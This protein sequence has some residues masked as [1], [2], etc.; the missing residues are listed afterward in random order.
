MR[1]FSSRVYVIT[2]AAIA[3]FAVGIIIFLASCA[4]TLETYRSNG[5]RDFPR[6]QGSATLSASQPTE[7]LNQS[8]VEI[9]GGGFVMGS[10]T[11]RNDE[12]PQHFVYLDA[13]RIDRNEVTNVQYRAYIRAEGRGSPQHWTEGDYPAAQEDYPVVGVGWDDANSYCAW[14]GKRLPTEAEWEKACRGVDGRIYPWGDNWDPGRANVDLSGPTTQGDQGSA[15]WDTAWQLLRVTPAN[16]GTSGLR[17][18]GAY[19]DGAS[20]YGVMDMTGNAS[21]WVADW[22]NWTGYER[23][24]SSNPYSSGPPWNRSIRGSAWRDPAGNPDWV[25]TMS[26]CSARSSSHS[27]DDPRVGF[28]CARSI[29]KPS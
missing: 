25:I 28:R 17:P 23:M 8:E 7:L 2:Q 12:S 1:W 6:T 19:V 22:Y 27:D 20:P 15:N 14:A 10:D 26:R 29:A 5:D 24:P 13:F 9:P 3:A 4:G 21:E 11:G 16:P 18:V